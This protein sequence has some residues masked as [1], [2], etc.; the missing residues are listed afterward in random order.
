MTNSTM[1]CNE[2]DEWPWPHG[3]FSKGLEIIDNFHIVYFPVYF[4]C[5]NAYVITSL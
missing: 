1:Y 4:W 5:H 2:H 3:K